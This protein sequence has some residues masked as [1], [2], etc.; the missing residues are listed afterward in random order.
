MSQFYTLYKQTI[1]VSGEVKEKEVEDFIKKYHLD[2]KRSA[3]IPKSKPVWELFVIL[4]IINTII[5][6]MYAFTSEWK[7]GELL[8]G[9]VLI[10]ILYILS[11]FAAKS[12]DPNIKVN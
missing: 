10:I 4:A 1:D 12:Q 5:G 8:S 11:Y 6:I 9:Y 3:E 2:Y 7:I